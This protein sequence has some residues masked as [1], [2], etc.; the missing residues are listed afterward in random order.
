[1]LILIT[2][3]T[4]TIVG[5]AQKRRNNIKRF[6]SNWESISQNYKI[7]EWYKDAKFGIFIH[8]GVYSVP[9]YHD[10]WYPRWMY[11]NDEQSRGRAYDYH[12]A[13]YGQ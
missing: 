1:M 5:N 8:W 9:A 7:P 3:F 4:A 11:K 13:T 2:F 10:E 12:V 6:E